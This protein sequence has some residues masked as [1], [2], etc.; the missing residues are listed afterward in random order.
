MI[1]KSAAEVRKLQ[2]KTELDCIIDIIARQIN[3]VCVYQGRSSTEVLI[4]KKYHTEILNILT[5]HGYKV[6]IH[7]NEL[8]IIDWS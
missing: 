7:G 5:K 3:D 2:S 6:E 1:L 8:F 4:P